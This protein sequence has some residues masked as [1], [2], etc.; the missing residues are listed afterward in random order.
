MDPK[1]HSA[2]DFCLDVSHIKLGIRLK[3]SVLNMAASARFSCPGCKR[4]NFRSLIEV[5]NHFIIKF[6]P[7]KCP[8]CQRVFK[9]ELGVIQHYQN[10]KCA[11]TNTPN[12]AQP[13]SPSNLPSKYVQT[14]SPVEVVKPFGHIIEISDDHGSSSFLDSVPPMAFEGSPALGTWPKT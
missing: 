4:K 3:F 5:K 2:G 13:I 14:Q 11:S 1:F 9:D 6:H 10:S 7:L 8:I 12:N